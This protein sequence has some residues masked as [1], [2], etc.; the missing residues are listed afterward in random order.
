M[1]TAVSFSLTGVSGYVLYTLSQGRSEAQLSML[2]R[3]L[4][5][6][7]IALIVGGLVGLLS[8]DY[9]AVVSIVCLSP[10]AVMLHGSRSGGAT[11][12][13]LFRAG[14]ALIYMALGSIA[15]VFAFRLRHKN[16]LATQ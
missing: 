5:S 4:F 15:A 12:D 16:D 6:P 1:G 10:W 7:G 11:P 2:I 8:N 13:W 9:P 14:P 3:F